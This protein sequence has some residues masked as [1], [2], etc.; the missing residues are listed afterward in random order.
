MTFVHVVHLKR[1]L[2]L[3]LKTTV[4]NKSV[5]FED[6]TFMARIHPHKSNYKYGDSINDD[7]CCESD[8]CTTCCSD[9]TGDNP[10]CCSDSSGDTPGCC[11]IGGGR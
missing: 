2:S 4:Y 9:S 7:V 8:G 3:I 6:V 10:G 1:L 5:I 11:Y